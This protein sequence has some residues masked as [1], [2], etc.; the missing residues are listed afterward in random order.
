LSTW[1][2]TLTY[3]DASTADITQQVLQQTVRLRRVLWKDMRASGDRLTF[4]MAWSSA[5]FTKIVSDAGDIGITVTKDGAAWFK[6]I[7]TPQ[8]D[9]EMDARPRSFSIEATDLGQKFRH[10]INSYFTWAGYK[11]CDPASPTTSIV[12][13]LATLAG[14]SAGDL[15]GI[16]TI[17]KTIDL[18]SNDDLDNKYWDVLDELLFQ[19]GYTFYFTAAGVLALFDVYP[20]TATASFTF[21]T[22]VGGNTLSPLT[23]RKAERQYKDVEVDWYEHLTLA[24]QVVFSETQGAT[25]VYKCLIPIVAGGYY[26]TS[27]NVESTYAEFALD[28]YEVLA[29][30]GA[31]I[32]EMSDYSVSNLSGT[33]ESKRVPVKFYNAGAV[34]QYIKKLDVRGTA[35]VKS[36]MRKTRQTTSSDM[37]LKLDAGY[38][39]AEADAARLSSGLKRHYQYAPFTYKLE[40]REAVALGAIVLQTETAFLM[41]SN[42]CVIVDIVERPWDAIYEYVLEGIESYSANA[43]TTTGQREGATTGNTAVSSGSYVDPRAA[44]LALPEASLMIPLYIYPTGGGIEASWAEVILQARKHP[45]IQVYVIA[46][47]S[48]GP[49]TSTDGNYTD[50]I[51]KMQGAGVKVLGYVAST[52]GAKSLQDIKDEIAAWDSLYPDVDGLFVDEVKYEASLSDA[53]KAYY[54][55]IYSYARQAWLWPIVGNPGCAVPETYF[56]NALFDICVIH[57]GNAWPTEA[58][59]SLYSYNTDYDRTKRAVLVYDEN[60]STASF[61]MCLK[62]VGSCYCNENTGPW[63]SLSGHLVEQIQFVGNRAVQL[64]F[65]ADDASDDDRLPDGVALL[66]CQTPELSW[67]GSDGVTLPKLMP[68]K[69]TVYETAKIGTVANPRV[70]WPGR[71]A[72][73][74]GK[75]TENKLTSPEDWS[76]YTGTD[77]AIPPYKAWLAEVAK[78]CTTMTFGAGNE[79]VYRTVAMGAAITG[80]T[81]TFS[82]TLFFN[83]ASG[84]VFLYTLDGITHAEGWIEKRAVVQGLN[85]IHVTRTFGATVSTNIQI[86]IGNYDISG[87]AAAGGSGKGAAAQGAINFYLL[88]SQLEQSAYATPFTPSTRAA[89]QCGFTYQF[90]DDISFAVKPWFAYDCNEATGDRT[91]FYAV[92]PTG[93]LMIYYSQSTDTVIAWLTKT[94]GNF[95]LVQTAAFTDNATLQARHIILV[96]PDT[97]A[98]TLAFYF[99]G[100]EQTTVSSSGSCAGVDITGTIYIGYN[101]DGPGMEADSALGDFCLDSSRSLTVAHYATGRPYYDPRELMNANRNFRINLTGARQHNIPTSWTDD[102]GREASADAAEGFQVRDATGKILFQT[103]NAALVEGSYPMGQLFGEKYD[104]AVYTLLDSTT[105]TLGQWNTVTIVSGGISNIRGVKIKFTIIGVGS[106]ATPGCSIWTRPTGSTWGVGAG[107]MSLQDAFFLYGQTMTAAQRFGTLEVP[108]VGNQFDYFCTIAP[109]NT[110]YRLV[111]QQIGKWA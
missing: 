8:I 73:W 54:Q 77:M 42:K 88:N 102:F 33:A 68:G 94:G 97:T 36:T 62:Y 70:P 11:V 49:G 38:L 3:S 41:Q 100:V 110:S 91:F 14:F 43:V 48:S 16:A 90:N 32:D 72:I 30:T 87:G 25:E 37:L 75:A 78:D 23:T 47:P 76:V 15:A 46:N 60:Y 18:F 96:K 29:V 20:A 66:D 82:I 6:G 107:D 86:N 12:H 69:V 22:G 59:L 79:F 67:H 65:E 2:Y 52:F 83:S 95:Y 85:T 106:S 7:L 24:D 44:T 27:S 51:K 21:A 34:T 84:Y 39:T 35:I 109:A 104:N 81:W 13:A 101:T 17:D 80:Q 26:P 64:A 40:S 55:A 28:G 58:A 92:G 89:G 99:D 9:H 1:V 10:R 103:P 45:G 93:F 4:D 71:G 57:E 56:T 63:D 5:A 111:L 74:V 31:V 105:F 53:T 19:F 108:V 98:G 61:K 50:A